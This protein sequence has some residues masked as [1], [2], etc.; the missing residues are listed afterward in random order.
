MDDLTTLREAWE[1]VD[2]PAPGRQTAARMALLQAASAELPIREL[3]LAGQP[4]ARGGWR[5]GTGYGA[6]IAGAAAAAVTAVVLVAFHPA[7]AGSRPAARHAGTPAARLLA[8]IATA[9]AAQPAARVRDSEFEYIKSYAISTSD[10]IKGGHE[11]AALRKDRRQ[12][13]QSVSD[14]CRT[15]L[16]IDNGS[17]TP[18]SPYPVSAT[19]KIDKSSPG[20]I[21]GKGNLSSPTYRM[22]QSLPA[23]PRIL[24]NRIMAAEGAGH[25]GKAIDKN[26]VAFGA[27]GDLLREQ[28]VPPRVSAALYRA[29]GLIPGVTLLTDQPTATGQRGIAVGREIMSG[30]QK[31]MHEWIFSKSTLQYIGE[32]DF[33]VRTGAVST[34]SA[35]LRRSFVSHAGQYPPASN[36]S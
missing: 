13:W 21:C 28:I 20:I 16:L 25:G 2:P 29:A 23:S 14:T 11:K 5:R 31:Y 6:L 15:G 27:I 33:N 30:G 7:G 36:H 10:V 32:R 34:A 17:R 9:A 1:P 18:L 8:K 24:L 26:S 22:L 19:G 12:V 35:I 4:P 3:P